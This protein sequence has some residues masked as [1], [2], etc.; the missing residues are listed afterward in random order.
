LSDFENAITEDTAV[1]SLIWVNNEMGVLFTVE[2]IGE[3][4]KE[5]E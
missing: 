5:S 4:L 1:V 3:S 2:K